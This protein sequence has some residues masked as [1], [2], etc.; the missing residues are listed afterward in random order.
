MDQFTIQRDE[1]IK[2]GVYRGSAKGL[3]TIL[4]WNNSSQEIRI[5]SSSRGGT[6]VE[7]WEDVES[8]IVGLSYQVVGGW[9]AVEVWEEEERGVFV[10]KKIPTKW[11]SYD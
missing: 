2:S 11:E 5:V 6:W 9:Q 3:M 8:R 10:E 1:V 7:V 4:A